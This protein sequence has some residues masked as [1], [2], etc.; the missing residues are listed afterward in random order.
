MNPLKLL[1]KLLILLF[2]FA[3]KKIMRVFWFDPMQLRKS[4]KVWFSPSDCCLLVKT[5]CIWLFQ[6]CRNWGGRPPPI[7]GRSVNPIQTGVGRLCPPL[8]LTPQSFPPSGITVFILEWKKYR[9]HVK[10]YF[11]KNKL[12]MNQ[13]LDAFHDCEQK[14]IVFFNPNPM[15]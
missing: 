5:Y 14:S 6:W 9:T 1:S 8:P 12:F 11:L 2:N 4:L 7:F 15:L 10:T 13:S 3:G